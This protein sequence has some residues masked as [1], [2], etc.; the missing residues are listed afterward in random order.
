MELQI[1]SSQLKQVQQQ[2]EVLNQ[3]IVELTNVKESLE[4]LSD[5]KEGTEIMSPLG[6]G[7]FVKAKV[8]KVEEVLMNVGGN[9]AVNK[10]LSK[11]LEQVEGQIK[12]IEGIISNLKKEYTKGALKVQE[13]Q[14]EM[15]RLLPSSSKTK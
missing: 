10:P 4:S 14:Q 7:I 2:V 9:V 13:L 8:N 6:S 1:L 3:Q 11:A 5:S 12:D 15:Q